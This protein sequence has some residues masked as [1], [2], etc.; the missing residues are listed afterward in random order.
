MHMIKGNG[1]NQNEYDAV[2]NTRNQVVQ[3]SGIQ[4]VRNQNRLIV[5]LGIAYQNVNQNGNGNVVAA[6]AEGDLDEIKEVNANCILMANLQQ[7]S[8]SGTQTDKAPIYDSYG[9]AEGDENLS[10]T[11]GVTPKPSHNGSGNTIELP[12]GNNVVPLRYDTIWL[13]QTGCSFHGLRSEDLNQHL[14]D[15]LK[16][17]DLLDLNGDNRERTRLCLFQF[18]LRNQAINWLERLP[19]GSIS[20]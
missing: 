16:L 2:R 11:L 18:S 12:E 14:K 5:V 13:V 7:A 15:F 10:V 20:T 3:N 4:N 1:G 9:S 17:V 6:R 19:A 8:I